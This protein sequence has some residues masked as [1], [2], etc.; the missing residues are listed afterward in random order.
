MYVL[1][2]IQLY[3]KG[4]L[5]TYIAMYSRPLIMIKPLSSDPVMMNFA[6]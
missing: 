5:L 3:C 1:K 6:H 2:Y 4:V